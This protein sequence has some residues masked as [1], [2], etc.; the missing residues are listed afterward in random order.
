MYSVSSVLSSFHLGFKLP[1]RDARSVL[2]EYLCS[3]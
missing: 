2:L 1:T 3:A